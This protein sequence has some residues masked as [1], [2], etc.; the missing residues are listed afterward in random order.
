MTKEK[1]CK[2]DGCEREYLQKG[3]CSLH[4][5]RVKKYNDP[6]VNKRILRG[7]NHY[8]YKGG[9]TVSTG[10]YI[11]IRCEGHPRATKYGH[12]VLEHILVM[13]KKLRRYLRENEVIHHKNHIKNDN[14]IE[15]L[16]LLTRSKHSQIHTENGDF[17]PHWWKNKTRSEEYKNRLSKIKKEWWAKRRQY[18]I[19]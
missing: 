3:Y 15:N 1:K 14:R 6:T 17:N 5:Q 9:K 18:E 10:G 13:E 4:Y 19:L 2:V 12:Y 8:N 7:E 11:Y 16:E